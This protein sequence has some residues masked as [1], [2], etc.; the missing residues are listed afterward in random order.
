MRADNVQ[1][2]FAA[3]RRLENLL[4]SPGTGP[5]PKSMLI[6][7][8]I[9][10]EEVSLEGIL[11]QGNFRVID[12]FEIAAEIHAEKAGG[13]F[14]GV[15]RCDEQV[16]RGCQAA[17]DFHRAQGGLSAER[18]FVLV[19]NFSGYRRSRFWTRAVHVVL[20]K[21]AQFGRALIQPCILRGDACAVA[22]DERIGKI[23]LCGK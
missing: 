7:E 18:R 10:G 21:G 19:Q 3:C 12:E 20:E 17:L 6:E 8:Y 1:E 16:H 4:L 14:P 9:P 5:D 22:H 15:G 2:F 13:G 11:T 23:S